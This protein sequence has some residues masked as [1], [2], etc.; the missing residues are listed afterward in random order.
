[1]CWLNYINILCAGLITS[2]SF[3]LAHVLI[4]YVLAHVSISHVLA[5]VSISHVMTHVSTS[6]VQAHMFQPRQKSV[7]RGMQ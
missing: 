2:I 3:V 6:H 4:S 7:F 5:H 1:M